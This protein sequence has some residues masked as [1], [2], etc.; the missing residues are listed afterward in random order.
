ME[1]RRTF[2]TGL[3][4]VGLGAA[5]TRSCF[6]QDAPGYPAESTPARTIAGVTGDGVTD[7]LPGLARAMEAA[8]AAGG[9]TLQLAPG[10]YRLGGD[11]RVPA[12]VTL[13]F[14]N[15][16]IL[17]GGG[18]VTVEGGIAAGLHQ[19]FDDVQVRFAPG[20]AQW[21]YPHW[22]GAR[23]DGENDD[24]EALQ[25]A[26]RAHNVAL[27]AG[28]YRTTRELQVGQR[29]TLVGVGNS[30]SPTPTTD[31]WIQYDGPENPRAAVLR[32][33]ASPVGSDPSDAISSVHIERVVLN[34]GR[35]AGFG[36]Y[37]VYCTND[38]TFSDITVR[39]C[40]QHGFFISQQ[41]YASYRNLVARNNSGCGIT[42]GA[43]FDGWQD[44]GV[45][46]V[47]FDNLRAA[48][49]GGDERFHERRRLRWGYGVLF[50]PGA[51]SRLRHVVSEQNFG[52]GLIYDLGPRPATRV[53]GGYLEGNGVQAQRAGASRP[54]GL[55]VI[56]HANARANRISS[57]Y[58]RGEAGVAGA[59]AVWLTGA[60]PAGELV[61]EDLS[62]GHH[63]R[64][65]WS[66]YRFAGYVYPGLSDYIEGQRPANPSA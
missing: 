19:L 27:P 33:A 31:S 2:L 65:E 7:D 63:L 39:Q 50:R 18:R 34:G 10:A 66:A 4:G 16:A 1:S 12:G 57:V 61:L 36:L 38:S 21:V 8:V 23:G 37:S 25:A 44:R 47:L 54:W 41:W 59:Q 3:T 48:E 9:A 14:A 6:A 40:T 52:P 42:I 43:V 29:T 51:G 46:G 20:G 24:T 60:A 64:A 28:Q 35:K 45:N 11:L 58:L 56:G 5:T 15:G 32:V 13:A 26:I 17:R 49:N 22:W 62:Y 55:V 30:W 53:E